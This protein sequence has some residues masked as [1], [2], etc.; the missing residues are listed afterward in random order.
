MQ[1]PTAEQKALIA[2][3]RTAFTN[4]GCASCHTPAMHLAQTRFE[5]PT[6]RGNGNFYDHALAKKDPNYDPKR[7]FS[8]DILKDTDEPRAEAVIRSLEACRPDI[9]YANLRKT[10]ALIAKKL[11]RLEEIDR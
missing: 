8:V 10:V 7:P 4:V 2:K 11:C 6:A 5:E 1:A 9:F 3:G